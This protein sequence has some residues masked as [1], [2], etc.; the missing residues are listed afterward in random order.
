VPWLNL[1][2]CATA[3]KSEEGSILRPDRH[4][5]TWVEL[6]AVGRKFWVGQLSGRWLVLSMK[7]DEFGP[8]S[9]SRCFDLLIDRQVARIGAGRSEKVLRPSSSPE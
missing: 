6:N 4:Q 7:T 9:H 8:G 2:H 5:T 1:S 3:K